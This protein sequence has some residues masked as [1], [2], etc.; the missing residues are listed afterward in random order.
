MPLL[1]DRLRELQ[2]E[3]N[4]TLK[5]V[6]GETGLSVSF[7]SLVER[8]KVSI[9]VDNLERLAQF[10]KVRLV[11]LFQDL[12]DSKI[13]ALREAQIAESL[14]LP[15]VEKTTLALLSRRHT[16]RMEPVL[17]RIGPGSAG[18]RFPAHEGDVFLYVLEGKVRLLS[19]EGE[20]VESL[21]KGDSAYFN[22]YPPR[23]I[24]NCDP[25]K[26]AL[27]L[28]VTTPPASLP[29]NALLTYSA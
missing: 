18:V 14:F 25:E 29:E 17:F 4:K 9:S 22:G 8:D 23:R 20:D 28:L 21:E 16:S 13:D 24:Q 27:F 11:H 12:E 26:P 10:Y 6:S 3:R 1:G 19:I 2:I 15:G 7:L 5:Q